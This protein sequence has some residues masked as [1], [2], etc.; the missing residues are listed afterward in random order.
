MKKFCA[1][2][3]ILMITRSESILAPMARPENNTAVTSRSAFDQMSAKTS[4]NL[5]LLLTKSQ[6]PKPGEISVMT[7]TQPEGSTTSA[8]PKETNEQKTNSSMMT[9]LRR[10]SVT[11]GFPLGEFGKEPVNNSASIAKLP[12]TGIAK[13]VDLSSFAEPAPQPVI[14]G[15]IISIGAEVSPG[16]LEG[17]ILKI[18]LPQA[19]TSPM[20]RPE[21]SRTGN[22]AEPE[23]PIENG[24]EVKVT[25][26]LPEPTARLDVDSIEPSS[27]KTSATEQSGTET[28]SITTNET[29]QEK[30]AAEP[31]TDQLTTGVK[32][33]SKR[34]EFKK[35]TNKKGKE[36]TV[37]EITKKDQNGEAVKNNNG[38]IATE[39]LDISSLSKSLK[40]AKTREEVQT[41]I[42]DL[43]STCIQDRAVMELL[44]K[45]PEFRLFQSEVAAKIF[46]P[47]TLENAVFMMKTVTS[48]ITQASY[49]KIGKKISKN[50]TNAIGAIPLG[51]GKKSLQYQKYDQSKKTAAGEKL[52]EVNANENSSAQEKQNAQ[53]K[54]DAASKQAAS[55]Y[56]VYTVYDGVRDIS[57]FIRDNKQKLLSKLE[58]PE[59]EMP[60]DEQNSKQAEK[61][62]QEKS[63]KDVMQEK[64]R[65]QSTSYG[66]KKQAQSE[67]ALNQML[68]TKK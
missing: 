36:S 20:M 60:I 59:A 32:D 47:T 4:E 3:M 35:T 58:T 25:E 7:G 18:D 24:Q 67:Y 33:G 19:K 10:T 37:L 28:S 38:T 39:K 65:L 21:R 49:G 43:T 48:F 15:K 64:F 54:Y 29:V 50:T 12:E 34:Y 8:A 62:I 40:D 14:Q 61:Q 31:K 2:M 56:Q 13:Q 53:L 68:E 22:I 52:D 51:V 57:N 1:V 55:N 17:K 27:S 26:T 16:I 44:Q 66:S 46:K 9:S 30:T 41:M 6:G 42:V 11:G 63:L 23:S 45:D 5:A